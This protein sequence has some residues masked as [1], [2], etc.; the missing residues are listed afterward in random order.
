MAD[1]KKLHFGGCGTVK[2][3]RLHLDANTKKSIESIKDRE[4][5]YF[6]GPENLVLTC[7]E[8][9]KTVMVLSNYHGTE[10]IEVQRRLRKKEREKLFSNGEND[11]ISERI[12]ENISIPKF[13]ADYNQFLRGVDIFDQKSSYYSIQL[14]SKRWYIKIFYHFLDIAIINSHILYQETY[15]KAGKKSL[16]QL[17]FRM[18]VIR[19]LMQDLRLA[20]SIPTPKKIK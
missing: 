19:E 10:K 5:L 9:A 16:D 8:D 17:E 20:L 14:G 11:M 18:E 7:W 3:N 1:L 6:K 12:S 4:I 15:R 13:I 2:M